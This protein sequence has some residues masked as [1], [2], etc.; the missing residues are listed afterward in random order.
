MVDLL[1]GLYEQD[2]WWGKTEE[3]NALRQRLITAAL[4]LDPTLAPSISPMEHA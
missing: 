1:S 4:A 2:H 3:R